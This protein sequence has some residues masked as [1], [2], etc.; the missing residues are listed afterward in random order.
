MTQLVMFT[1]LHPARGRMPVSGHFERFELAARENAVRC[2][3][4]PY[5]DL[6]LDRTLATLPQLNGAYGLYNGGVVARELYERLTRAAARKGV[7]MLNDARQNQQVMRFEQFYDRISDL[8]ARSVLLGGPQD[9]RRAVDEL[10]LPV[11]V[12][13]SIISHKNHGQDACF[14]R[15]ERELAQL[16][17]AGRLTVARQVLA[18]R[19]S[20]ALHND[21]PVSREYRVYL[22]CGHVLGVGYYWDGEDPFGELTD[23]EAADVRALAVQAAGR[24]DTPLLCV[25]VGQLDDRTWKII[26]LGDPQHTGIAHMPKVTYLNRLAAT[27]ARR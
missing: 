8:T 22:Y 18:L 27:L 2:V 25:D 11:F 7:T 6:D 24:V 4:L 23:Q 20:G 3:T 1:H 15:T 19:R 9:V 13:G 21:F 17:A 26:E 5:R 12:K 16:T 10:G 14:A